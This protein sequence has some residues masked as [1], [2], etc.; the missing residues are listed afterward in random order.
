MTRAKLIRRLFVAALIASLAI[1]AEASARQYLSANS[2][3][4]GSLPV[5]TS[6]AAYNFTLRASCNEDSATPGTCLSADPFSPMISTTG[7]FSQS[8]DCPMMMPGTDAFGTQCTITVTFAPTA[9]GARVGT[10]TTGSA[11]A[12]AALMGNGVAASGAAPPSGASSP[13][14]AA[15][16]P[17]RKCKK[18]HRHSAITSKRKCRRKK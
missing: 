1:T 14:Q 10:L 5:G 13:G 16:A 8:N 6:G 2:H 18:K 4:F 9:A 11:F 15:A 17:P 3:D 7:D 12:Q